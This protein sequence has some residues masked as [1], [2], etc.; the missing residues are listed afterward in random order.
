MEK[1]KRENSTKKQKLKTFSNSNNFMGKF[2]LNLVKLKF[3]TLY[4][5]SQNVE[6]VGKL[7]VFSRRLT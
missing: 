6:E 3:H 4:K 5:L 2:Y 1:L 7:P